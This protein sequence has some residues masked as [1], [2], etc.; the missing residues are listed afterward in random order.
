MVHPGTDR[1]ASLQQI[2][3]PTMR[4]PGD[5]WSAA[6][7][8][9]E[10]PAAAD[11][12]AGRRI[13]RAIEGVSEGVLEI[14]EHVQEV[15]KEVQPRLRGWLHAAT[16]PL[17]LA[18]GIVLVV[19]SPTAATR[20]GSTLFAL[21]AVILFTASA[22]MHRGTWSPRTS[23]FLRRLDHSGIFL[24]IAGSYTPFTL[25]L[26][27]GTARTTLLC[28]AWGGAAAGIAF[29]VLWSTAPRW[30]YTPVYIALGWAAIFFAHD[31]VRSGATVVVSLLAAGGLLYTAGAVV[32][33]LRRPNPLPDWFGFHEV[34][35]ALTV[36]AF[37]AHYVGISM[38]TYALR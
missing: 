19:L 7:T 20:I 2:A 36:A 15:L 13:N 23:S 32:Y 33:G 31:F 1:A 6:S 25:L 27:T 16:A 26:L 3:T 5:A 10:P 35:H 29:R 22:T 18:A 4:A 8:A 24:L 21:S 11:T 14:R 34:F 30:V 37:V 38:A 17:A 12:P 9:D 28:L